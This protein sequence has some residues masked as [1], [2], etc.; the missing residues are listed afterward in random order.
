M[1]M[2]IINTLRLREKFRAFDFMLL[3]STSALYYLA[4]MLILDQVNL[5]DLNSGV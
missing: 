4:G 2:H 5:I 1:A 3:L